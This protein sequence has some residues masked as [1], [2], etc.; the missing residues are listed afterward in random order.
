MP[1]KCLTC[2][3]VYAPLLPDGMR[4]FHACPPLTDADVIATLGLPLVVATWTAAQQ[5]AFAAAS[6]VR[7]NARDEN[8]VP[9]ARVGD[10]VV[11]KSPGLG[12]AIV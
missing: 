5:A 4:Y 2:N 9:P 12:V 11:I 8:I 3:G 1:T 6:R 10:P 7:P